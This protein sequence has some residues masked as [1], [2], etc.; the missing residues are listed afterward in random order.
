MMQ[1]CEK[2]RTP[3]EVFHDTEA[4]VSHLRTVG[5]KV[6]SNRL[7]GAIASLTQSRNKN[8]SSSLHG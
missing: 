2:G 5:G 4:G 3:H 6:F 8:F 1:N 7:I